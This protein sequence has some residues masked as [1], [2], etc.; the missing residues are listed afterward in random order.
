MQVAH[1]HACFRQEIGEILRHFLR[2]CRDEDALV[3]LL[4]L[5]DLAQEVIHLSFDGTHFDGR[6]QEPR[7]A[8][9]LLGQICLHAHFIRP[10][11]RRD[12]DDL[13]D[14]L[15]EF[16]KRQRTVVQ[17]RRQAEAIVDER[18]FSR[19]V[20][21]VHRAQ[22]RYRHMRLID[23]DEEIFREV[24]QE[25]KWRLAGLPVRHVA[26]IIL[27]AGAVSDLL[28]HFQ[29]IIRPLLET[30]RLQELILIPELFEPPIQLL[31]DRRDGTAELI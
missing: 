21:I 10:R 14:A 25:R 22:L 3:D 18:A 1:L 23:H 15:G 19:L 28:H 24:V 30:L 7:R 8:D 12:V 29:V 2:E 31:L 16:V 20:A 5:M 13:I 26:G 6:I 9:D 4:P 17:R 27:D 11:R